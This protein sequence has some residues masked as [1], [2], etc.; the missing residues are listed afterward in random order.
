MSG[1]II[2]N[3]IDN[4]VQN[5]DNNVL[6]VF[7]LTLKH[8]RLIEISISLNNKELVR[9]IINISSDYDLK[10]FNRNHIIK[11]IFDYEL[12]CYMIEHFNEKIFIMN[13]N[14]D[15]GADYMLDLKFLKPI[16]ENLSACRNMMNYIHRII[17]YCI[18]YNK[19]GISEY[20]M[21]IMYEK[22]TKIWTHYLDCYVQYHCTQA[23]VILY[24]IDKAT[25]KSTGEYI[26]KL[27]LLLIQQQKLSYPYIE[28]MI[29]N[30]F[31]H[32]LLY[33]VPHKTNVSLNHICN[34][35]SSY[36]P[37][38]QYYMM[39]VVKI[40]IKYKKKINYEHILSTSSRA[41]YI[42]KTLFI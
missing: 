7:L 36:N 10:K 12:Y 27:L 38:N 35:L 32:M 6:R 23:E 4:I 1:H 30:G 17:C 11:K 13:I 21:R 3:I 24:N 9:N 18:N 25:P 2:D 31:G 40:S 37:V 19:N 20:L 15:D 34:I 33:Y 42:R 39:L 26:S 14:F 41:K 5:I 8:D 16:V 28:R 22:H 29:D